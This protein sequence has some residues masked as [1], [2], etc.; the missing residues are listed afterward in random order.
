MFEPLGIGPLP[1]PGTVADFAAA[2]I[3]LVAGD[4]P[5]GLCRID[6]LD[7]TAPRPSAAHLE[8]LSVHPDHAGH[9]IGRALLRE[10]I[11]WASAHGYDELTLVT[12]RD[13][14]WNAPFY[15]SEGFVEIG[16]ARRLA[17]RARPAARGAR[18]DPGCGAASS[19]C[20]TCELRVAEAADQVVVD[21]AGG[22]EVR[23]D[24][25]GADEAETASTQVLAERSDSAEVAGSWP[26]RRQ[27]LTT[28]R[29]PTKPQ[30]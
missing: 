14:P 3:V 29:P 7:S 13:V 5:V 1:G 20:G 9:G 11:G 17:R 18:H 10:A 12:Y 22:L 28:G 6:A 4:P 25:R 15:A 21:Q 24:D 19:W 8:Q 26:M 2:L 23:V 27:R 16:P 30:M